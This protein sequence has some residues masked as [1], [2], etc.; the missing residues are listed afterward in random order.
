MVCA[1]TKNKRKIVLRKE[2]VRQLSTADLTKAVG[3]GP[4]LAFETGEVTCVKPHA[5]PTVGC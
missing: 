1:M 4:V 5:A 3:G 2:I